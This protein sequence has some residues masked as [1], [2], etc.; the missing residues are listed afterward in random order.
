VALDDDSEPEP[1]ISVVLGSFR[2]YPRDHP[3]RAVLIVEIADSSL[4]LDRAL[5]GSLYARARVP[6]YW[7]VNIVERALEV[8]RDPVA[9]A[10]ARYE[11]RYTTV[12]T[13]RAGDTITPLAAPD[14]PISVADLIP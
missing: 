5:K 9:D 3:G 1:D 7:I 4:S 14:S 6:D 13:L 2:D 10:A 11:W 12:A 8:H